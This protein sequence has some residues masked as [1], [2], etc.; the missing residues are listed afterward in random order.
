MWSSIKVPGI[1][2]IVNISSDEYHDAV[3]LIHVS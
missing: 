3:S 2:K 1:L